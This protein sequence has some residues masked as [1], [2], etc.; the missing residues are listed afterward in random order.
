MDRAAWSRSL[1]GADPSLR[2]LL[3]DYAARIDA[4]LDRSEDDELSRLRDAIRARLRGDGPE[5]ADVARA[6]A[7]SERSLQ[8]WLGARGTTFRAV[9]DAV[10]YEQA[11][12]YLCDPSLGIA[13]V[14]WMLGFSDQR[15][16]TR[17][18]ARWSGQPPGV[19]RAARP[20]VDV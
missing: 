4:G 13:E 20:P 1:P 18:F 2:R 9:V 5:L 15:A 19:W 17:A 12:A 16:F 7:T 14:G 11:R 8:R 3:E 6:L 10:R